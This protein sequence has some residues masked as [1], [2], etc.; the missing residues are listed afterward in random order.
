MTLVPGASEC[1]RCEQNDSPV[2]LRVQPTQ[3]LR[4]PVYPVGPFVACINHTAPKNI[5][6]L[7]KKTGQGQEV[8]VGWVGTGPEPWQNRGLA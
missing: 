5:L 8:R 4:P 6:C 1:F 3:G 2:H 7:P